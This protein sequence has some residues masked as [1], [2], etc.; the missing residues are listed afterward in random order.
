[1]TNELEI[2]EDDNDSDQERFLN[3][4]KPTRWADAAMTA[5]EEEWADCG[6]TE[7]PQKSVSLDFHIGDT[8]ED[9]ER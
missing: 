2:I 1:M 3:D 4:E 9:W 8:L 5:H 7:G 6:L